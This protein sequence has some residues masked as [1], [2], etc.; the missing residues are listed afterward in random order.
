MIQEKMFFRIEKCTKKSFCKPENEIDK[1]ISKIEVVMFNYEYQFNPDIHNQEPLFRQET[2]LD[3]QNLDS[4]KLFELNALVKEYSV[5]TD[6]RWFQF[7]PE[8]TT[9]KFFKIDLLNLQ[10]NFKSLEMTEKDF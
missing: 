6:D 5:E 4:S 9:Y 8:V 2:I 7:L 3:S 1:F 10:K